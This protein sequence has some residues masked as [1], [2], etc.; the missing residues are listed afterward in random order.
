MTCSSVDISFSSPS[1]C[2]ESLER[3]REREREGGGDGRVNVEK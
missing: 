3:E 1:C 2:W